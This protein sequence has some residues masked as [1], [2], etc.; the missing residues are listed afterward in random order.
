MGILFFSINYL[1][2][3]S[4]FA[5]HVAA[6]CEHI[7][8][9]NNVVHVITGFPF[10]P[11]WKRWDGYKRQLSKSEEIKGVIVHR[12]TH[13]IP[14]NPGSLLQ[15]VIMEGSFCIHSIIYFILFNFNELDLIVYVGAQPSIAFLCR[16]LSRILGIPYVVEINDIASQ[17]ASD[18]KI[19]KFNFLFKLMSMF[20][21]SAYNKADGA[22]VLCSAFKDVLIK[23]GYQNSEM[24]KIIRSP[25]NL[26]IVRITKPSGFLR[27]KLG[28]KQNEFIILHA[29]SMGLKQGLMNVINAAVILKEKRSD[30]KWVLIG[31]GETKKIIQ[32]HIE[33][34]SLQSDVFILPFQEE[35]FL[36]DIFA[37]S[38]VLL[39][40]QIKNMKDSVIPS[41]LLT[42]MAAG[43]SV[44]A[45]VNPESQ[46]ANILEESHGGMIVEPENPNAMAQAVILLMGR[47]AS[48]LKQMG[49]RNREY[50]EKNFDQN[51][52]V[53]EHSDFFEQIINSKEN[54]KNIAN[55]L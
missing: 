15:R 25:V 51:K 18:V 45:A 6:I 21:F 9:K 54:K 17:A 46:G 37:D 12:L 43:K 30:V 20:E 31:D 4:G 47:H 28:I 7:A 52:I 1:P 38:D 49:A 36:A 26:N 50:A 41:K 22:I 8:K 34:M 13:F 19:I 40:N 53:V 23:H 5:P 3:Q 29:G 55:I 11:H 2:E 33:K 35:K 14:R 16:I 48:D 42:Y 44:L 39:L 32:S 27:S 24:I 10:S